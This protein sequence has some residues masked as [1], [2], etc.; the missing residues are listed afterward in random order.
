MTVRIDYKVDEVCETCVH[1]YPIGEGDCLCEM[2]I[3]SET[4]LCE[5]E[6]TED[7]LWCGGVL[8]E[9]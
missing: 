1:L 7:Y 4:P 9:G 2:G 5:W 8:W 3:D 6:P